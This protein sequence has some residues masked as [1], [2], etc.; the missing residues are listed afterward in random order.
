[1]LEKISL[2]L[3]YD[4]ELILLLLLCTIIFFIVTL[5]FTRIPNKRSKEETKTKQHSF[6]NSKP[7]LKLNKKDAY[8]MV[9]VT[10]LFAIICL[11]ELGSTIMPNT[12]WQPTTENQSVILKLADPHFND[13]YIIGQEGDNNHTYDGYQ[14]G[15]H[16]TKIYGSNDNKSYELITTLED[17]SFLQWEI[18]S[19]DY[20]YEYIKIE[21]SNLHT[22]ITEIG[23]H[24]QDQD[25]FISVEVYQD[26]DDP[27][28][29]ANLMIDEQD[30]IPLKQTY[31]TNTYFDEVYHPRNAIEIVEGQ[32]MY[33]HVHPLLGTSIIALGIKIFGANP[34]G[35]RIMGALFGIMMLPLVYILGKRIFNKTYY[36]AMTMILFAVD[37]MHITTS[38]IATLEPFSIFFIIAMFFFMSMYYYSSFYD[39]SL[40]RQFIYLALSGTF[41]GMAISTKWTGCYGAV[42]LAI[43]FF[44]NIFNRYREYRL[45]KKMIANDQFPLADDINVAHQIVNTFYEKLFKT[46]LWCILWFVIIP[47]IMYFAIYLL[48]P[49]WRDGWSIKNVIDQIIYMYE[50]HIDLEATHPF[51]SVWWQWILDIR[52]IWYYTGYEGNIYHTISCL[53]NPLLNWVSVITLPLCAY[54]T[55]R[56]RNR[57][58]FFILVG[59]LSNLAPWFLVTRCVFSYHY[60]PSV[61][62]MILSIVFISKIL[63]QNKPQA[64]RY[65]N[66]YIVACIIIF[67]IYLPITCGFG[68]TYEFSQFLE[69]FPSWNF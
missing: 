64:K 56:Y 15:F 37:F 44:A 49:V 42:G 32:H 58:G 65:V 54:F 43:L 48:T 52:P 61:I 12:Y 45:A 23:F 67:I 29:D 68:T 9:L 3:F 34:F 16:D 5:I 1:M 24:Q 8:I 18:I 25:A 31:M 26:I 38:R 62:F 39:T 60:Y 69:I 2:S 6:Y 10:A 30:E 22:T 41:M 46:I 47:I 33:A 11:H 55:L 50:Y 13:I 7:F 59:Y 28:Y 66:F 17:Y 35:F 20:N 40:K 27:L 21:T 53:N 63:I 51:E 14:L 4:T 36:A 19:G 57:T